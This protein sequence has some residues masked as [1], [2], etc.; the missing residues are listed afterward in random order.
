MVFFRKYPIRNT[1]KIDPCDFS[2]LQT[3]AV[4]CYCRGMTDHELNEEL[5]DAV[6]DADL[7]KIQQC[8]QAGADIHHVRSMGQ[9]HGS[10]QP[11]TVLSM[12]LFR[13]SDNMLEEPDLQKFKEITAMLLAHGADT[14]YA[15][16]FAQ[17]RYGRYDDSLHDEA[18]VMMPVWHLI[19]QAHA[20]RA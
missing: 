11:V 9:D 20:R 7:L 15:M 3:Q 14:V 10:L 8:L 6:A 13:V 17:E 12:V 2:E 16:A 4:G 19:A 1:P 18:Y 5:L